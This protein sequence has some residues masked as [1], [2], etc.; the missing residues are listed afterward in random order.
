[1]GVGGLLIST[2]KAVQRRRLVGARRRQ[3][4]ERQAVASAAWNEVRE[5]PRPALE[6]PAAHE[7][8]GP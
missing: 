4:A 7:H 8:V 3:A 1:M 6:L 2:H 5:E